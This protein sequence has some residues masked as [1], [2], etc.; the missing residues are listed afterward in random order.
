[1]TR[2][3]INNHAGMAGLNRD[4]P[5]PSRMNGHPSYIG[6]FIHSLKKHLLRTVL[7]GVL[8]ELQAI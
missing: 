8:K 2:R 1:M 6:C 4:H 5:E 7:C 3:T